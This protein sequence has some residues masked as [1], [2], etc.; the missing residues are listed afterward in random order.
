MSSFLLKK[1]T[2][3]SFLEGIQTL[4]YSTRENYLAT[5]Q[6]FEKFCYSNYD[7]KSMQDIVDEIKS[8]K[9]NQKDHV[10]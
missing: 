4:Q 3:N 6:Q 10:R 7:K 2:K 8:L 9:L 1:K 5:L